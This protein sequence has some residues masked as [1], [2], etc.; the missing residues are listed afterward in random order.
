MNFLD[1][2]RILDFSRVLAGPLATQ[3]LSDLGAEVLK[4][5]APWG[6]DTRRWGPP[7]QGEMS[8]Y[9]QSANRDKRSLVLDLASDQ[10][11][12]R[13]GELIAVADVVI[14][15]FLPKTRRTL[16]LASKA[17]RRGRPD[18]ITLSIVGY[19][20]LR[21]DDPGYD[22]I[23][24]AESGFLG[25]TGAQEGAPTKV[26]VPVV[27]TVT[28]M[29]AANGVLAALYRRAR[30]GEGAS[31]SI[32]LFQTAIFSLINVV[33]NHLVSGEPSRRWGNDH[34]NLV[35]YGIFELRDR[36]IALGVGNDRQ[37]RRLLK[38]LGID[39]P[40]LA[41][42]D[43]PGRVGRRSDVVQALQRAFAVR[44]SEEILTSLRREGI[45]SGLVLR[46]DEALARAAQW[47]PSALIAMEH[48][49]VGKVRGVAPPV[50][51][52]GVRMSFTAPPL[53]GEGG[54]DLARKWLEE[55]ENS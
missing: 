40:D 37:Y 8:A 6:D 32:S 51:G 14:D 42:L 26:G 30:T 21:T 5:E 15:N 50:E 9:F 28:G 55:T 29:M 41:A 7:F 20:G 48:P 45:P 10:G 3:I 36:S 53:L 47:D 43:N 38:V 52:D 18:L 22:L 24:Q 44:D 39:A 46:P 11:S 35:P 31:L 1:G 17:L 27:D 49:T 4:I 34:P 23:I 25:V 19:R 33:S 2:V 16:G 12:A 13:A 54:A